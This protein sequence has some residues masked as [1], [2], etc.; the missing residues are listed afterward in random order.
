MDE[1]KVSNAEIKGGTV[2]LMHTKFIVTSNYS[3]KQL[4]NQN[5]TMGDAIERRCVMIHMDKREPKVIHKF[6][7]YE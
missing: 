4:F 3:I 2:P 6:G 7:V 5:H 1:Y